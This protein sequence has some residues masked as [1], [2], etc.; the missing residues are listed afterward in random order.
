MDRFV[1]H[2]LRVAFP[3]GKPAPGPRKHRLRKLF[4][5]FVNFIFCGVYWVWLLALLPSNDK[6]LL[7]S[8]VLC[9][10]PQ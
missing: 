10:S 6:W 5:I 4:A 9:Q 3:T 8:G 2:L 1:E 7:K